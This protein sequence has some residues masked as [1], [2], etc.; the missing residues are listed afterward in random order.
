MPTFD[1]ASWAAGLVAAFMNAFP[2]LMQAATDAVAHLV[3]DKGDVL[4]DQIANSVQN[5]DVN[6]VTRT[7]PGLSYNMGGISDMYRSWR[8]ATAGVVALSVVL[9]GLAVLGREYLGWTWSLGQWS[10]RMFLGITFATSMPF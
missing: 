10:G 1:P 8:E 5:S 9:A 3:T 7:P 6:F 4:W 2:Q